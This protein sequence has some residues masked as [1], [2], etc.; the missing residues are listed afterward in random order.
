MY[1]V[2]INREFSDVTVSRKQLQ[3]TTA[4]LWIQSPCYSDTCGMIQLLVRRLNVRCMP[5]QQM[6]GWW[7]VL[8]QLNGVWMSHVHS[9]H[10]IYWHNFILV[11][12]NEKAWT[13]KHADRG[14]LFVPSGI[15]SP[16]FNGYGARPTVNGIF[17]FTFYILH[18]KKRKKDKIK[19]KSQWLVD[20]ITTENVCN[21]IYC[22][23]VCE[24]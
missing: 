11:L 5:H 19:Q 16:N 9:R 7:R 3:W 24:L 22:F 1:L 13:S 2:A 20:R 18:A 23:V 4:I 21:S 12:T 8:Y 10:S 14:F 17:L 6:K 15:R